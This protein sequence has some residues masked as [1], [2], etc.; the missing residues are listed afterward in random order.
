MMG[1]RERALAAWPMSALRIAFGVVWA[2][3]AALKW[4][5]GFKDGY[6]ATVEGIAAGQ[7][8]GL[9]W[10]FDFWAALM[11][12]HATFFWALVA[13]IETLIALA[14]LSGFARKAT[15]IAAASRLDIDY[16]FIQDGKIETRPSSSHVFTVAEMTRMLADAGFEVVSLNGG[17]AGERYELGSPRLVLTAQRV[18]EPC[19]ID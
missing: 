18:Q 12:S 6:K 16:T 3:D 17:F 4:L 5:P 9:R 15:Y 7:P 1:R 19:T 2:V 14:L 13:V 10:W 8:D 11:G